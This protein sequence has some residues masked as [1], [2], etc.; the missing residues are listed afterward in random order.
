MNIIVR[1]AGACDIARVQEIY[2]HHVL[3]GAAS[4]EE[5]APDLAELRRRRIAVL[6]AGLPYLVAERD[7]AVIGYAYAGRYRTRT[8][9][10]HTAE[11]SVYVDP[12]MAGLGAGRL[13][14][15]GVIEYSAAAGYRELVAIIGDSGNGASI[16]LRRALG[17]REAGTLRNVGLKFGRW[18]DTVIM[19]RSV[20]ARE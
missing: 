4:F 16:G 6:E 20:V 19:Q 15:A 9:Y 3:H 17:F 7:G 5:V 14:L 2:K 11:D 12:Q 10:R 8:A 1:P 18:L 13:L